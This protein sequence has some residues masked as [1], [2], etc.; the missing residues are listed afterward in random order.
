MQKIRALIEGR[1]VYSA[2]PE[3]RVLDVARYMCEK[4]VGAIVVLNAGEPV[5][6]FSER[7]LMERVV[8]KG[9][10]PSQVP[11]SEVMTR[12]VLTAT[13]DE[14]PVECMQRMQK[15]GCRHLPV[16]EEGKV[17]GMLSLRDLL[18]GEIDE[19]NETIKW[20]NAYIH[21]VPPE[22]MG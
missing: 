17:I 9:R 12:D 4:R 14:S 2:T 22:R 20:M 11:V 16:I 6:V 7:D 5:G 10:D 1:P 8:I 19:K 15:R 13:A 3:T 21:D 18:K